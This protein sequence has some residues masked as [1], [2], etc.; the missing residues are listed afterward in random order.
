MEGTRTFIGW[1]DFLNVDRKFLKRFAFELK[2]WSYEWFDQ[3]TL[4]MKLKCNLCKQW[5][6]NCKCYKD[7]M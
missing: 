5:C 4:I 2:N 1:L 6:D 3:N 7:E